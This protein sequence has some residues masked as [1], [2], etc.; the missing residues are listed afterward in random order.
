[1][2]QASRRP[3]LRALAGA[4]AVALTLQGCSG[5]GGIGN[6]FNGLAS[7]DDPSD[8]CN[9]ARQPLLESERVFSESIIAGAAMGAIGGAVAGASLSRDRGE[10]AGLGALTGGLLGAVG[11][12]LA[13]KEQHARTQAELIASIDRDAASDNRT[14]V[15][16]RNAIGTL[17][18]C[19][20]RQVAD[21]ERAYRNHSITAPQAKQQLEVVH[22]Q[23]RA[24]NELISQVLGK[25]DER[26]QTYVSA[27]ER[28]AS[29]SG[30]R[31]VAHA[32]QGGTGALQQTERQAKQQ[33]S[34][35][36][37]VDTGLQRRISDLSAA[38]G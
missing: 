10:G 14:L 11:G 30:R 29:R 13:A 38:V 28:A 24:D 35:H 21:V 15:S 4:I 32:N 3:P 34:E 37:Q 20:R 12:Y 5:V 6:M 18:R 8:S 7:Y 33:Q 1:M 23:M 31:V 26:S 36:S 25:V 17:T 22:R 27:K 16:A 2:T 9:Y 19:R